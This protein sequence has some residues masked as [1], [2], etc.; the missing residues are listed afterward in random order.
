MKKS[1]VSTKNLVMC[2]LLA[3]I[4][5]VL[6]FLGS[7]IK[8][9]PF[10]ISLVL[11]PIVVG[12]ALCGKGAGAFLGAV[13]GL[14]VFATDS[15][16]FLA[17]N[18]VGTFITV[19]LKGILAGFAAGLIYDL[20]KKR[21]QY[22]AA[23]ASAVVCPIVNTGVFLIFCRIFFMSL[24]NQWAAEFGYASAGEYIIF[25]LVGGNFIFELLVNIVLSPII[26]KLINMRV[27]TTI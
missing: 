18:P 14:M 1:K 24:I 25:A 8:F 13:F 26:V 6:Q 5:V 21:N 16:L 2:A 19:M 27:K 12:A 11:I 4:I 23:V 15:A 10:S 7:F 3:A 9:G 22:L 17:I 20:L